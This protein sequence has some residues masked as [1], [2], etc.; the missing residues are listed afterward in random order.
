MDGNGQCDDNATDGSAMAM[1]CDDDDNGRRDSNGDSNGDSDGDG[2]G[3]GDSDGNGD[4]DGNC[5]GDGRHNGYGNGRQDG[6]MAAMTVMDGTMALG[7]RR[8]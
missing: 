3:D 1:E 6:N 7:Q 8:R 5:D 2:N 4:G